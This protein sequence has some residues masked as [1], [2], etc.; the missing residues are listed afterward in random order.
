[1]LLEFLKHQCLQTTELDLIVLGVL[2]LFLV[3]SNVGLPPI[4]T[5]LKFRWGASHKREY[6]AWQV[7]L[8]S[9]G[10]WIVAFVQSSIGFQ[11]LLPRVGDDVVGL[12]AREAMKECTSAAT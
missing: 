3:T 9:S 1:M 5:T 7:P 10:S 8:S 11:R 2:Q 12:V 6:R 4:D